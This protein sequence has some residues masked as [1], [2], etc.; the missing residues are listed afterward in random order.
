MK[1]F[2]VLISNT[3]YV[4]CAEDACLDIDDT[5]DPHVIAVTDH[6][7]VVDSYNGTNYVRQL[8]DAAGKAIEERLCKKLFDLGFHDDALDR[9]VREGMNSKLCDIEEVLVS[10]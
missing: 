9:L 5:D 3:Y 7:D 1:L 8:P 10:E 2:K 4:L 6:S